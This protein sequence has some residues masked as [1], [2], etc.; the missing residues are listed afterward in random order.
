MPE[1]PAAVRRSIR[2]AVT[3]APCAALKEADEDFVNAVPVDVRG[4]PPAQ[5]GTRR[6]RQRPYLARS[7]AVV[8]DQGA[9]PFTAVGRHFP[10]REGA[11]CVSRQ[12]GGH[13]IVGTAG[14]DG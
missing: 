9:Q 5:A 13:D 7:A 4:R 2:T 14:D 8:G 1:V 3:P 12:R 10:H 11:A 6:Q